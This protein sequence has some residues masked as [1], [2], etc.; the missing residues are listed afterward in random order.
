LGFPLF[1]GSR[2]RPILT[3]NGVALL[4]GLSAGL[5]QIEAS[6]RRVSDVAAGVLDVS[7]LSTFIMR[8]LIP[9]LYRFSQ[10]HPEIVVRLTASEGSAGADRL[11]H[12]VIVSVELLEELQAQT[13]ENREGIV[14]LFSER[15]GPVMS[16]ALAATWV[17]ATPRSLAKLPL[18]HTRTRPDAWASR[19]LIGALRTGRVPSSSIT[20]TPWRPQRPALESRWLHAIW[21]P[22]TWKRGV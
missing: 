20:I 9:R 19:G 18:L 4:P 7:C 22:P 15:L 16:P 13:T 8:W 12:D 17:P 14:V 5:E 3:S 21:L 1:E 11:R 10:T 2:H 6:L